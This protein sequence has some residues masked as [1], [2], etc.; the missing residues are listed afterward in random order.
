MTIPNRTI[1]NAA[2]ENQS[3]R[4]SRRVKIQL[5]YRTTNDSAKLRQ[6]LDAIKT[7]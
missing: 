6:L 4:N 7:S 5:I 1:I 2:V 3:L